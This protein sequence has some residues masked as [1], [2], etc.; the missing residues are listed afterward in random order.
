MRKRDDFKH[1]CTD[2][3]EETHYFPKQTVVGKM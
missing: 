1:Y 3:E 2:I